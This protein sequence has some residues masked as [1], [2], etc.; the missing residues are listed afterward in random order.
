MPPSCA[1]VEVATQEYECLV[2]F[3]NTYSQTD[4]YNH[5]LATPVLISCEKKAPTNHTA[6]SCSPHEAHAEAANRRRPGHPGIREARG[7]LTWASEGAGK[8]SR[9]SLLWENSPQS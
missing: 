1:D 8:E 2:K 9:D 5:L 7:Y 3:K 4:G 6:F